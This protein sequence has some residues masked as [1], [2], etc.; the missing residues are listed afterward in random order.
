MLVEKWMTRTPVMISDEASLGTA[1]RLLKEKKIR[2]L[3]IMHEGKLAGIVT[4]RDL[5][6]ASPS[7]AT[8]LDIWELHALIESLKIRE[9]MST[10]LITIRPDD[11]IE[12]A[13]RIMLEKRIGGLPVVDAEGN[14]VG[15]LTEADVFRALVEVTGANSHQT[16]ISLLVPDLP[17][18]IREVADICRER[19]GKIRSIL[20]SYA[21]VPEGQRELIMRVSCP[22]TPGLKEDLAA[23]YQGVLVREDD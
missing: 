14:L 17:G 23:R 2:R 15:M 5:K 10:D 6:A 7:K 21:Q 22:D 12:K 19:G 11:T 8:S 4:D 16:R 20:A 1:I 13:A 18:T 9:I 3:P